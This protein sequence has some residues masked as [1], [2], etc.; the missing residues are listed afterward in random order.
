VKGR[1]TRSPRARPIR[2]RSLHAIRS[3]QTELHLPWGRSLSVAFLPVMAALLSQIH[4]DLFDIFGLSNASSVAKMRDQRVA[5]KSFGDNARSKGCGSL[6]QRADQAPGVV[7][8][9]GGE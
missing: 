9:H 4:A 5:R 7:P 8:A 1:A 2:G 6:L 3:R